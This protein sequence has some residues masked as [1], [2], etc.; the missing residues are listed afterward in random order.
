MTLVDEAA[1]DTPGTE[2]TPPHVVI[3]SYADPVP[4]RV[5]AYALYLLRRGVPVDLVT[6]TAPSSPTSAT[7][8]HFRVWEMK[9]VEERHPVKWLQYT[10]VHR[11]PSGVLNR[12]R[13]VARRVPGG[14]P[15]L[16]AERLARRTH[17]RVAD[18]V[19]R[20]LFWPVYDHVRPLVLARASRRALASID[21]DAVDR[22]VFTDTPA[23][24]LAWK[25]AQRH[26]ETVV[27]GR[28]DREPYAHLEQ[29]R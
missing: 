21:F 12:V 29:I 25:L 18:L 1:K 17:R 5:L 22:V 20:R 16:R 27:D 9:S 10:V 19:D 14:G 11:L 24:H 23:E 28:L 2:G 26:P 15:V 7:F 3:L 6:P 8:P 4:Q 13:R